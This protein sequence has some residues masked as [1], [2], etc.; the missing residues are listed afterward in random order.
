MPCRAVPRHPVPSPVQGIS[1][2][3]TRDRER[4]RE[5]ELFS[6]VPCTSN[7]SA[8]TSGSDVLRASVGKTKQLSSARKTAESTLRAL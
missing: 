2:Q 4:E 8:S 3:R 5:R 7:D 1:A 6:L